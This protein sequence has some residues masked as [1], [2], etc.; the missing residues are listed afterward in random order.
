[1]AL[2]FEIHF[3]GPKFFFHRQLDRDFGT[4]DSLH[5]QKST[6]LAVKF[7]VNT[8]VHIRCH[9]GIMTASLLILMFL[10]C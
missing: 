10:Y 7:P 9:R 4:V 1:M 8:F 3:G 2:R 5:I 6:I